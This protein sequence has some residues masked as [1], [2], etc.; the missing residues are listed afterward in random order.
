MSRYGVIQTIT[1]EHESSARRGSGKTDISITTIPTPGISTRLLPYLLS[2]LAFI[3]VLDV[4]A[5][6]PPR[7]EI[8]VVVE[9]DDDSLRQYVEDA[10]HTLTLA[11]ARR[12]G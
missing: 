1:K 12:C 9:M 4:G 5:F 7:E 10:R 3:D 6:M 2:D 11:K 8:P